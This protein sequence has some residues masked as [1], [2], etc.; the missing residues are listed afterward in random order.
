MRQVVKKLALGLES[1]LMIDSTE[2]DV[3]EAA[4]ERSPAGAIVNS[5]H[6][7]DGRGKIERVVPLLSSTARRWSR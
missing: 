6:L 2:A 4:L 3:I 5:I 1:P 7:E